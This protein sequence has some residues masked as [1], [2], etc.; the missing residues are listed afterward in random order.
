[1]ASLALPVQIYW[2]IKLVVRLYAIRHFALVATS[3][4]ARIK[5]TFYCWVLG[6]E[7]QVLMAFLLSAA[8]FMV[9]MVPSWFGIVCCPFV[10]YHFIQTASHL[11]HLDQSSP[12][13]IVLF[14][15]RYTIKPAWMECVQ[16]RSVWYR[17]I[18]QTL[19]KSSQTPHV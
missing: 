11:A 5:S 8:E 2:Y 16:E 9:L 15:M 19:Q 7:T 17:N 6:G 13:F 18:G 14:L 3:G 1:M 10:V 4:L 12:N